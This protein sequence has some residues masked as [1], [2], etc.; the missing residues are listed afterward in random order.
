MFD[1]N[2]QSIREALLGCALARLQ[3][4]SVDIT[5][6]YRN[7]GANAFNGRTLDEQVVNPFLKGAGS[8]IKRGLYLASFRRSVKF[9]TATGTRCRTKRRS[10]RCLFSS[11]NCKRPR[12]LP[13]LEPSS[14]IF[15][16]GS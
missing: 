15:C 7:H 9:E 4:Q 11:R 6:P 14:G 13:T 10:R 1:S 2:T 5:L 3:D 12:Q 16:G 8:I